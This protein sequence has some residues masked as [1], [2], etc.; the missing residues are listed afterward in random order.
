MSSLEDTRQDASASK[1]IEGFAYNRQ[2]LKWHPKGFD[3][4]NS[5]RPTS[6][7]NVH[8]DVRLCTT[9]SISIEKVKKKGLWVNNTWVPG[10]NFGYRLVKELPGNHTYTKDQLREIYYNLGEFLKN[11]Q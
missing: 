6:R 3:I 5:G 11:E 2:I 7:R 9:A 8:R 4:P 1:G 10:G